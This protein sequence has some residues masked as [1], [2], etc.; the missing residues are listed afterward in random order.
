MKYKEFD[1]D[2]STT[3][4]SDGVAILPLPDGSLICIPEEG[5]TP[6]ELEIIRQIREDVAGRPVQ[7]PEEVVAA[8]TAE[9]RLAAVEEALAALMGV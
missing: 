6:E 9:D 4:Y 3:S 7:E 5:A 8:P 2:V 1:I